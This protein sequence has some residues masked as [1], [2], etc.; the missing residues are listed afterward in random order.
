MS[1]ACLVPLR[2]AAVVATCNRPGLL[3]NRSLASIAAQTRPPDLLVVVDD[4]DAGLRGTNEEITADFSASGARVVYLENYR[5]RGAS[6]AWNTALAYLQRSVPGAFVAVLDDDDA[7][8]ATYLQRCEETV[9]AGDL[10]MAAAG[11]IRYESVDDPGRLLDIPARLDADDFLV[12]NPNIQGSNLFVRLR[13]ILEAGGF[14]EA[15]PSTTDRDVCI[16]IAD[17]GYV[18]FGPVREHL[19]H[20]Y[21]D[22]DRARL[23]TRGSDVKIEGLRRFYRKY[24]ARM[25]DSQRQTFTDRTNRLFGYDPAE[26]S[27]DVP[28]PVSV[29]RPESSC[30]GSADILDLMVGVIT[31]PDVDIVAG[32]LRDLS[33]AYLQREDVNLSVL[34]LENGGSDDAARSRLSDLVDLARSRGLNVSVISRERQAED[35]GAGTFGSQYRGEL[36]EVASIALART[37]LQSYLYLAVNGRSGAVVWILDD[38]SRLDSLSLREDG[39]LVREQPDIVRFLRQLAGSGHDVIIGEVTGEPPLPFSSSIRVQLVDLC[40]NLESLARMRPND[41]FLG[42]EGENARVR[43]AHCDFYYDL[44]RR[45]TAHLETPFWYQPSTGG[46]TVSQVFEEMVERAPDMLRGIQVFR[47]LAHVPTADPS[48]ELVPSANRGPNTFV[49]DVE[50]LR[51]FPNAASTIGGVHTRRSDMVWSLLNRFVGGRKVVSAPIP[52]RQ[53]RSLLSGEDLDFDKLAQDVH[54][55]AIYS[56]LHDVLLHKAQRR[57][58][59]RGGRGYGAELL[60]FDS[61]DLDRAQ[62]LFEKYLAERVNAFELSY[63]RVIGLLGWLDR[64][65]QRGD[66]PDGQVAWWLSDTCS[67]GEVRVLRDMTSELR[68][69]YTDEGLDEFRRKVQN[70]DIANVRAFYDGLGASVEEYRRSHDVP[71]PDMVAHASSVVTN[72]FSVDRLR[73]LGYGAEGVVLTDGHMV[74]KHVAE[75]DGG[76]AQKRLIESLAGRPDSYKT[77]CSI[78]EV[79]RSGDGLV[80]V[81]PFEESR[82]YRGG[83]L[84]DVLTFLRECRDAGIISRNVHPDNFI[85]ARDGLRFIDYGRDIRPYDEGEFLHMCRRAFLSWRFHFRSD[86]KN[87]MRNALTDHDLPELS[88]FE[89]FLAAVSPRNMY[90]PLEDALTDMVKETGAKT[91]LDYGCGRGA[92]ALR[93]ASEGLRVTAFDPDP[94]ASARWELPR[95]DVEFVDADGI[96][97]LL[98][99]GRVFDSVV[100]SRVLCTIADPREVDEALRNVR[101]LVSGDGSAL[102]VVCNPFSYRLERTEGHV[103]SPNRS[104]RYDSTFVYEERDPTSEEWL[105]EVH[106]PL[107]AYRS[108]LL[109]AGFAIDSVVEIPGSDTLNMR[110]GSDYIVLRLQPVAEAPGVSLMIKTCFMEWLTIEKQVRHQVSQLEGPRGFHEKVVVVDPRPGDFTRQYADPDPVAHREAMRRLLADG[111]VDRVIYAP[112]DPETIRALLRRWFGVDAMASHTS[113]GQPIF[114]TLWGFEQCSSEYVLQLDSDLLIGRADR[115]HDYVRDIQRVFDAHPNALFAPL[116]IFKSDASPYTFEGSRGDWRVEVRGC[117][118]KKDRVAS[119]LPIENQVVDET[120]QM[121]WH[122]AFDAFIASSGSHSYRG[123]NPR[124]FSSMSPTA[125]RRTATSCLA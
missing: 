41:P 79:R 108:A 111:V 55:Y 115:E 43:M 52:I 54:G 85:V 86:L 61:G 14:D 17:L 91:A 44:S 11:L 3:A 97:A 104:A 70:Y 119:V 56:A 80:M 100:C 18:R 46:M 58:R 23:S 25:S 105:S 47:P 62:R 124:T 4:S 94:E 20:H 92:L 110:P 107:E 117:M 114:A 32:L 102:V 27:A 109:R 33:D 16:R 69:S 45:D 12:G 2:I 51:E 112:Q 84:D 9:L 89:H 81:Y 22:P 90:A 38:D 75:L 76:E 15:L 59:Q 42:R 71:P 8:S 60:E 106:R 82:P 83:R 74:Y 88:G 48:L 96:G 24:R 98:K 87:L 13:A 66:Q 53:D 36:P 7:W 101:R 121:T 73:V 50:A 40:H 6:G 31:S 19:V 118:V 72:E 10:D 77:L 95:T 1:E 125:G 63:L 5:T 26:D 99:S 30:A 34:L 64:F 113:S 123:G 116:S 93:L 68:L 37:M 39:A 29:S 28:S 49:F 78:M 122:R 65:T 67:A 35:L 21:A 120:L 57:Q 103:R